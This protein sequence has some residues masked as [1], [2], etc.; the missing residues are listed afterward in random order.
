MSTISK[1][2]GEGFGKGEL[3]AALAYDSSDVF[4]GMAIKNVMFNSTGKAYFLDST[5]YIY[6]PSTGLLNLVATQVNPGH[7]VLGAVSGT[8]GRISTSTLAGASIELPAAYTYGESIE[9]R[10]KVTAWTGI[11]SSYKALYLRSEAG[12]GG[13]YGLRG[14]EFYA[15]MN[16][17]TTTGLSSL[18]NIYAEMLVKAG[19]GARTLTAGHCIE[20]N[21]S[22]E[23]Q[24]ANTLTLTNDI[25]CLYAK[26]QT[27]TGINDYTK[28]NGIRI[29]G[30]DDGTARVFGIALNIVDPEATV[31]TW[32][33]G[34]SISSACALA[35]GIGATT[36]LTT[37]TTALNAVKVQSD[38][39]G[40][41][42]TYHI[43]NFFNSAYTGTG[44]GSL[45]AVVGQV[46]YSGTQATVTTPAQYLVGVHGRAK[47]TGTLDST[48]LCL[49]GVHAQILPG[50]TYTHANQV[51]PLWADWQLA[52]AVSGITTTALAILSNNSNSGTYNPA[53]VMYIYA[54]NVTYLLNLNGA[55]NGGM[56]STG[57][58]T[59]TAKQVKCYIDGVTYYINMYPTAG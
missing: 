44:T 45:R 11:G 3:Y 23:N 9:L 50:G 12:L 43:A 16:T 51:A 56:V 53:N 1:H 30:R 24:G 36:P 37:V 10:Y 29:S 52:S 48:V 25:Y 2:I 14:A 34:I 28:V 27:G 38:F 4:S 58:A 21:I 20:A 55:T 6:S 54:P 15:V 8:Y 17:S 19:A 13:A 49:T 18:Q 47:V 40:T 41:A 32:T 7:L 57:A 59:G 33:T 26:A 46:D 35:L 39:T 42:S 22:I 31:C 5:A